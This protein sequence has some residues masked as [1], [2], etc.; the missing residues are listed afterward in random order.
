MT[1]THI[2]SL[3]VSSLDYAAVHECGSTIGPRRVRGAAASRCCRRGGVPARVAGHRHHDRAARR[4]RRHDHAGRARVALA[5]AREIADASFDITVRRP[6][7][8]ELLAVVVPWSSRRFQY[9]VKD[10]ALPASGC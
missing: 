10:V 4:P 7:G 8:H 1:P 3:T 9:T 5:S 2:V 6:P